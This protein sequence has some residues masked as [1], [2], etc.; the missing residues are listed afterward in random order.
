LFSGTVASILAPGMKLRRLEWLERRA[1]STVSGQ[2]FSADLWHALLYLLPLGAI[3]DAVGYVTPYLRL[4]F[5]YVLLGVPLCLRPSRKSLAGAAVL[6][7][8]MALEAFARPPPVADVC[9]LLCAHQLVWRLVSPTPT[10]LAKG[11][12]FYCVLHILLFLSPIGYP[13]QEA[14]CTGFSKLSGW[15]TGSAFD[16]GYTYQGIGSL[17][18]FLCLS[19]FAW[20][21]SRVS[22]GRTGAFLVV[23]VLTNAMLS[24][25]L[26]R[27][28][29]FGADFVW[30]LKYRDPN[31]CP[32]LFERVKGLALLKFPASHFAAYMLTYLVLHH[33]AQKRPAQHVASKHG[34]KW[35]RWLNTLGN[36]LPRRLLFIVPVLLVVLLATPPTSWRNPTES[37]LILVERGV[38]SFTKP[39]Y[40]RYGKAAGGMFGMLPDYAGLFGC[41]ARIVKDV[42]D[43]LHP[44]QILVFTN[45]DEPLEQKTRQRIWQFVERGGKLWV[46]GDHTFIKNGRNHINDLLSPAGIALNHDSAQFHPQGWFN[47]YRFRQGTPFASLEDRA[48][49]RTAI[50]VGASLAVKSPAQPFIMG[51]FGYSDRGPMLPDEKRGYLGD[52][53]YQPEERLGDLVLVAGQTY[54][55]GRVLV[56]GDTTSFFNNNLTRSYELLRGVLSWFGEYHGWSV[57]STRLGQVCIGLLV[58]LCLT[59]IV[60]TPRLSYVSIMTL[61]TTLALSL[62]D[63]RPTGLLAIDVDYARA[64]LALIDF[65]H[66]PYAS[67]HSSMKSGLHGLSINLMRHGKLPAVMNRWDRDLLNAA[68]LLVLNAPQRPFTSRER[69][70]IM[71]FMKRGG[72]VLMTCGFPHEEA[73]RPLLQQ[74][75][76]RVRGLPLGRFFDR[77]A[78][79][80]NVSFMS[81][82]PIEVENS[83]AS[84]LCAYDEWPLIAEMRVG[85]GRFVLIADSE[86]LHNRNLEG[87][88]NHDPANTRFVRSLLDHTMG[89]ARP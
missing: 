69:L 21:R 79:G 54:G 36:V 30:E 65:S 4:L 35:K 51:R 10:H 44:E 19:V 86:F 84:V 59:L 89:G 83:S 15:V 64:R 78:L 7:A 38:V 40:R 66:Q 9:L 71:A 29:D 87:I 46:L 37:E 41:R 80:N 2:L 18:L 5:V 6:A 16:L 32:E 62:V 56:F 73:S 14:L 45:L 27:M 3:F 67:R 74:L 63:H 52:F 57:G 76:L 13:V 43:P 72:T 61:S 42:P 68:G 82:W 50:L 26:I 58:L 49:N 11:L 22:V 24:A 33:D 75:K 48:E 8:V 70:D 47:S 85:A 31:G 1:V 81:A 20:D 77:Q 17:L 12:L 53:E 25:L 34:Q 60:A 88:E 28:V 23:A 39:D 55:R